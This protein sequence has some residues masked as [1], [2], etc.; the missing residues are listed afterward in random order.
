MK[1]R[2]PRP[3]ILAAVLLAVTASAPAMQPAESPR[4]VAP[5]PR[6]VARAVDVGRLDGDARI[7]RAVLVLP[8]RDP[9]GLSR[10]LAAQQDPSSP[11]YRRWL[12]PDEFGR[13][14]GASD[15]DLAALRAHLEANGL[16]VEDVPGGRTALVFSGRAADVERAFATELR[17]VW[18]DGAVRITNVLPARLPLGLAQRTAGLLSLNSFPRR[19]PLAGRVPATTSGN[20]HSLAP[21]D[22]RTLYG[23]D[24]LAA[25]GIN[26]TGRKIA[27]VA[28]TNV[29]LADTRFFRSY[30]GLPANDPTV[31][32][33]GTDPGV[34][35]DEIEADLDI[36][37]TGAV[38]PAAQILLVVTKTNL[39]TYGVDLSALYIVSN[40]LADVM[41][42]SYGACENS[43]ADSDTVFYTNIW[44]QAAAQG[45]TAFVSSGDTGVDG[46]ADLN[47]TSGTM[48]SVN[49]LGSSPYATCVG[50]T[51]FLD[52][53]NPSLYWSSTNDPVTKRSA[54]GPIPE[55]A[56]NETASGGSLSA[57][58]GGLSV[59]FAR[60]P[61][62][63]VA[64]VPAG[65]GRAV[66]DVSVAGAGHTPYAMVMG[67]SGG[68]AGLTHVYGTSAS[69]PAF[70]GIAALL[71]QR[72][73]ARLG[74]LNPLLYALGAAQYGTVGAP[75]SGSGPFHDVTTG[76]NTVP[77]VTGFDAGPGYDAVTGLGS[78]DVTALANVL[79]SPSTAGWD[80]VLTA[81][82][83][84][85]TVAAGT[86]ASITASLVQ[87]A[88]GPDAD[89][90]AA[91]TVTGLPAGLTG[92]FRP[93]TTTDATSGILS[94]A[95]PA[96][97]TLVA[98]PTVAAGTYRLDL[99]AASGGVVRHLALS[100]TVGSQ[101]AVPP[102]GPGVQAPVILDVFGKGGSHYTSDL[103][104]VNRG[105]A[106]V[107]LLLRF[108]QT[109]A[110][111]AAGPVV[112][113]SLGA[114]RQF[115]VPDVIAFLNANGYALPSDGSLKLGTL[116]A[117]FVGAVDPLAV[118]VGSRTST[119][120]PNASVG[121]SFGTFSAAVATGGASSGDAWIYGLREN[122]R[123]RSNLALVHAPGA[124]SG[125]AAGP[126][127]LEVQ[128]YDGDS[129]APVA[130]PL[131]QNLQPGQFFQ[132]NSILAFTPTGVTNGYV[133][134]HLASG[135]DRYIA[136]GVVNDGGSAGG[137]TSDG[138]FLPANPTGGLV[139]IV[140]D[141]PGATHYSSDLTLTNPTASPVTVTLTYTAALVAPFSGLGSGTR[142]VT[143]PVRQQLVQ[144]NA[145]DYLR[146]LGF[147][148]PP[149][150]NQG[151]TLLV[152]GASA[153][154]RTSN[155]NPDTSVGGTFG[156]A[157]PAVAAS[158]R[159]TA[160]AWVYGLR[161]DADARTNL[162]IADAR[163]G[164]PATVD[165]VIELYEDV[166]GF[167]PPVE[168]LHLP[169]AGGQWYQFNQI[170]AGDPG[171]VSGYARVYP[172]SGTSDFVVYGVVNDGPTAGSRTSD[173]SYVPMVVV[174]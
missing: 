94:R 61:W 146:S 97:L 167:A 142:T 173:G 23:I 4:D 64:G 151:G 14:F 168:T 101:T 148:I 136:Y 106:D 50:G 43:F 65:T 154:V 78:P 33:N 69:S 125:A 169:L 131:V 57:S 29:T 117:T 40:N 44:A 129:G 36:Q 15:A 121:G 141:L 39:P 128:I 161:Q 1:P 96:V 22:F 13:S 119:P 25:A 113:R 163:V 160:E 10:L 11:D 147:P 85:A 56:W 60:P 172:A 158:A 35:G 7:S 27:V 122:T 114:G 53:E 87:A 152:S 34:N 28:Q 42:L 108:A 88:G 19:R 155:P 8:V 73:G 32:V 124:A 82:P 86:S 127:T 170:G 102:T 75:V 6:E 111:S 9:A 21:A 112:A 166:R 99:A 144:P 165:Y 132:Y 54:K 110:P 118:Y 76:T 72:A 12:T 17:E 63:N 83:A 38:A 3:T 24:A 70:A 67:G 2:L 41:T 162:A 66:P 105:N 84:V 89:V 123:F 90:V 30:F 120:N 137:G 49:G 31:I 103:V 52:T 68:A 47:A 37:W 149:G 92:S 81:Q 91:L 77:G 140:L 80:F 59:L 79:G 133:R 16:E 45:I 18:V 51:Q 134:V 143:L 107:T 95:E 26:G 139:P 20:S 46:C 93:S 171:L 150:G 159:A 55:A 135:S 174:R 115:Y 48:Q 138:S 109:P 130:A 71:S 126:V 74:N 157:Y 164:D 145:I 100:V 98:A 104:A 58:G 5:V 156:V 153:L 62:Q 116:F